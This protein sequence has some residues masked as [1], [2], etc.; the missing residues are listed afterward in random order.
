[1]L[2]DGDPILFQR[3]YR[4]NTQY[5]PMDDAP[6]SHP[7]VDVDPFE[8][9]PRS[10]TTNYGQ[11]SDS[12]R[13][14]VPHTHSADD[15]GLR[16]TPDDD[17]ASMQSYNDPRSGI[18]FQ[19]STYKQGTTYFPTMGIRNDSG[20]KPTVTSLLPQNLQ[21]I[22]ANADAAT[23]FGTE[24]DSNGGALMASAAFNGDL[25][26]GTAAPSRSTPS[27]SRGIVPQFYQFLSNST[28]SLA[29][30]PVQRHREDGHSL[31]PPGSNQNDL[32]NIIP[33][34]V[35]DN[36]PLPATNLP[37][38]SLMDN[39]A[40]APSP[41]ASTSISTIGFSRC[42]EP[43]CR[44]KF[45][46]KIRKDLLRRHKSNV[47]GRK[48]KLIC[49]ECHLVFESGRRDN[50]K[51]H[52]N[53]NHPGHPSLA[54]LNV[55]GK[56]AGS[57]KAVAVRRKKGR[58]ARQ[59]TYSILLLSYK[60]CDLWPFQPP[61]CKCPRKLGWLLYSR[62]LTVVAHAKVLIVGLIQPCICIVLAL[63]LHTIIPHNR[64]CFR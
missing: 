15:H 41:S 16:P 20:I 29:A 64:Q 34:I 11:Y 53:K 51:R 2:D 44:A 25:R 8:A 54:S 28:V 7:Y 13:E 56:K 38:V 46:A 23:P 57:K 27:T 61:F 62:D 12:A 45:T 18:W 4:P 39:P 58:L 48:S 6:L 22:S 47:Y 40:S 43:G 3:L 50:L 37:P 42:E 30:F 52:I 9:L 36:S 33:R 19:Q 35:L 24:S 59:P 26:S 10:T 1:M 14:T 31:S 60:S 17:S 55:Q 21:E 49:P 32:P 5:D 63:A